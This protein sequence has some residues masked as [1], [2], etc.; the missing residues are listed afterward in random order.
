MK[1]VLIYLGIAAA[2]VAAFLFGR[3]TVKNAPIIEERVDTVVVYK[4]D[5]IT[6][7]K[8]VYV[9]NRAVDTMLVQVRDTLMLRDTVYMALEREQ[10]EYTD[11]LYRAW[12]SG[13]Q[14]TLDSILIYATTKIVEI[15]RV[16]ERKPKRWGIGVSAGFGATV[17]RDRTVNLEPYIGIGINYNLV[18]W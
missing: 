10:K 1:Q 3:V 12:V 15:E 17:S 5:T 18:S 14:P 8:P 4:I 9:T 2:L 11:S 13:Y 6:R 16:I 7:N